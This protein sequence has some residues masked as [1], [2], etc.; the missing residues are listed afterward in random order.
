MGVDR[1]VVPS[2]LYLRSTADDLAAFGDKVIA[3]TADL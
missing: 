1:V 2:F 3:P